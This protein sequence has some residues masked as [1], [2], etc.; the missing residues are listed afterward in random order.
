[1]SQEVFEIV[2]GLDFNAIETQVALQCAPLIAGL[3]IAN[4][5]I[6]ADHNEKAVREIL[7]QCHVC[8]YRLTKMK[9]KTTYLLFRR[10]SLEGFLGEL[11]VQELLRKD[12]Y[13]CFKFGAL[14]RRFQLRYTAYTEGKSLFPHEMGLFLGY[15]VEDVRGFTENDGKNFLCSGYW[16]V[17]DKPEEK[18]QLFDKFE[19]ARGRVL[20]WLAKGV[21]L[22]VVFNYYMSSGEGRQCTQ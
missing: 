13:T 21:S 19:A 17:Y 1:M 5:L 22:G 15:P 8:C 16:K 7:S 6:V 4:L 18:Q 3:K 2:Q 10:H 11:P 9:N 14:L 12:G 20:K